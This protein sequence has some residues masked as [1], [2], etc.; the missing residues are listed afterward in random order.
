MDIVTPL[1]GARSTRGLVFAC[2]RH[3]VVMVTDLRAIM[4][5]SA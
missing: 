3:F 2:D 4:R 1:S 5:R